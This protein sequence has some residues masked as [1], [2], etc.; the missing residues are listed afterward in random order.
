MALAVLL[1]ILAGVAT[2]VL[3]VVLA[4]VFD[5]I[6]RSSG[7]VARTLGL[8]MLEAID[9]IV[10]PKD[11]RYLFVRNVVLTP[12]VVA[13]FIGCTGLAGSMA[14]LSLEQPWT[15]QKLRKIPEAALHLFAHLSPE[16]G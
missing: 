12:L 5:H 4:E 8:P 1:A 11:R 15:Y 9:E 2:G 7:Q 13:C 16:Q 14:F 6:Y 3:F 10:T